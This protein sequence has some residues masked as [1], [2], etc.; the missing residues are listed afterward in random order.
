MVRL[1]V[2]TLIP[3]A[4]MGCGGRSYKVDHPVVGPAPPRI[5]ASRAMAMADEDPQARGQSDHVQLVSTSSDRTKPFEMTDV[6]ATVNGKPILV[7]SVLGPSRAQV[8]TIRKK[9]PP[10]QFR[11]IQEQTLREQLPTHVEQAMMVAVME[12][13]LNAD[14]TKAVNSQIDMLFEKQLED[15]RSGM[16]KRLGRPCSIA[17][18][19]ADIQGQGMTISVMRK[20]FG[21]KALAQQYIMGKLEKA[22]PISRPE[23]LAAYRERVQEF[24]EAPAVKWQQI[25]VSYKNFDDEAQA[26]RHAQAALTELRQGVPFKDVAGKYSDGPDAANGG[27]WD[28]TQYESVLNELRDPLSKLPPRTP[29]EIIATPVGLQIVQVVERRE[30][31]TKPFQEVQEQLREEIA[32]TR[33]KARIKSILEELRKE[34]VVTTIFDEADPSDPATPAA[35]GAAP[36]AFPTN[37]PEGG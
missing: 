30:L 36:Q 3:A 34:C 17:D 31:T 18:L 26:R 33:H 5:S 24:S 29:S 37:S 13:K 21:D 9:V 25:Q 32:D 7:A 8:E 1:F 12:T 19:E 10:A 11:Q 14:Q 22:E 20:M 15:M 4:L 16:E 2:M 6:I 35:P 27:N 28:W 23:L